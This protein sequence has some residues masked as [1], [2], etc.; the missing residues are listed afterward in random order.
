VVLNNPKFVVF[1]FDGV[2]ADT[3]RTWFSVVVEELNKFGVEADVDT[4]M[5]KY[6][7]Y[8]LADSIADFERDFEIVL[9]SSWEAAVVERAM[10]EVQQKFAPIPRATETARAIAAAGIPIAVA[11]GS[12][13]S[14]VTAGVKQLGLAD[15]VG[16]QILSSHD[17]GHHKPDP[18]IYLRAARMLGFEP[19]QGIA[20]EDSLTGVESANKAGLFVIGF[21]N[22]GDT[23]QLLE[24]GAGVTV[25]DMTILRD[26]LGC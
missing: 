17:D 18:R 12:F 1:D 9:P 3:V 2:L 13:R 16:T 26:L 11:S 8:L 15:V 5:S 23:H 22:H 10:A 21:A 19:H 4:V 20:V 7:G 6:R 25:P 14:A 24:A